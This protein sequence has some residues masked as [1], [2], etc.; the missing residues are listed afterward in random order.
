MPH[1]LLIQ[2]SGRDQ[3]GILTAVSGLL[4]HY[5]AEVLDV[6]E[7]VIHSTLT[8]NLLVSLRPDTD[9]EQLRQSLLTLLEPI[10]LR[11]EV[12]EISEVSY[13]QWVDGGG[14]RRHIITL[15]V[16]RLTAEQLDSVA[17]ICARHGL[18]IDRMTR[19][20]GRRPLDF[21][22]TEAY[23]HCVELSVRGEA[24]DAVAL[25][26]DWIEAT[27]KFAMDISIQEDN[28]FRRHRRLVAFDMDSTLVDIEVID[29]L[30][31][32]GGCGSEVTELTEQAM[33]GEISFEESLR[34][35]TAALAGIDERLMAEVARQMPLTDGAERLLRILKKL[36]YRIAIISGGFQYFASHLGRVLNAD[37]V[38]ANQLEIRD[39]VITGRILGRFIDGPGKASLLQE[40]CQQ[41][42]IV[43]AQ[44]IAVG[45]GAN[46]I[47][48]LAVAGLGIAYRAK[49]KVAQASHHSISRGNLGTILFLLGI[50]DQQLSGIDPSSAGPGLELSGV[51]V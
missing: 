14:Q 17:R 42:R 44:S 16:E 15:L 27:K 49:P 33:E 1:L 37:Y 29:E 7:A 2:I 40:I 48:M 13:N 46:D 43:P 32:L 23:P 50:S 10:G 38:F 51:S 6:G 20:S 24:E 11:A 47:D 31:R 19:L 12:E 21:S 30:A 45:D 8:L 41:E 35:R 9:L 25:R 36:G 5:D 34:R 3:V 39:Q 28:L 18:N 26:Q 4:A 22:A